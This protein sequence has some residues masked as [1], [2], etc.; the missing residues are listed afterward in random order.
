M[1]PVVDFVSATPPSLTLLLVPLA[2]LI[3]HARHWQTSS[4]GQRSGKSPFSS[5]PCGGPSVSL[6]TS[7]SGSFSP[8]LSSSSSPFDTGPIPPPLVRP[9]P[10]QRPSC[11][12]SSTISP[13]SMPSSQIPFLPVPSLTLVRIAAV[14]YLPYLVLTY[15]VPLPICIAISGTLLIIHRARWARNARAALAR[16]AHLR[17]AFYHLASLLSGTPL[18]T[19]LTPP[20]EYASRPVSGATDYSSAHSHTDDDPSAPRPSPPLRFLYT[21]YENQRWWVGLDWTAALLPGER[22]SWCSAS[23]LPLPPPSTFSLPSPTVS[24]VPV[25]KHGRAKRMARWTWEEPE[26]R[27]VVRK[28]GQDD[29]GTAAR[30]LRAARGSGT[31]ESPERDKKQLADQHLADPSIIPAHEDDIVTDPEGW[32]Y[33]DNNGKAQPARAAWAST[34]GIVA[35][36]ASPSSLKLSSSGNTASMVTAG[37]VSPTASSFSDWESTGSAPEQSKD[38]KEASATRGM[39][40]QRLKAAMDGSG[41]GL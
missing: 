28:E 30:M 7:L 11:M 39:L 5:S 20:P 13:P 32:A 29:T 18:P 16:S 15:L 23:Q 34:Q 21:I 36:H 19:P 27:V 25:G 33:G 26:W 17:W 3:H 38:Q 6:Q 1:T 2:P 31:G 14:L 22:P 10:R 8:S 40:R 9:L 35:G 41:S 37:V 12:H 4:P 24:F